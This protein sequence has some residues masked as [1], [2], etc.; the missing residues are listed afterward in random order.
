MVTSKKNKLIGR[1]KMDGTTH[2]RV[3]TKG[4]VIIPRMPIVNVLKMG[5]TFNEQIDIQT[6]KIKQSIDQGSSPFKTDH[7]ET[8][9]RRTFSTPKIPPK[10][11]DPPYKYIVYIPIYTDLEPEE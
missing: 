9:F 1:S 6:A 7:M 4:G 3:S 8:M 10:R 5:E 11:L 2:H